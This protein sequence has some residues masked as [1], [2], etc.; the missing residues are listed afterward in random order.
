MLA[1]K[2]PLT[3]EVEHR[4]NIGLL[5]FR[6]ISDPSCPKG[7]EEPNVKDEPRAERARR[8]QRYDPR[9]DDSFRYTFESTR[10]D[11]SARWFWRLVRRFS[12]QMLQ[13]G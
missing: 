7:T 2:E 3:S 13:L 4:L 9:A 10:R 6:I 8:V 1:G 5:F 12:L 11:R